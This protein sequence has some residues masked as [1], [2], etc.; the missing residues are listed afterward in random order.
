MVKS[1]K[2]TKKSK[3]AYRCG[4]ENKPYYGTYMALALH[5]NNKHG[6]DS[7]AGTIAP[8]SVPMKGRKRGR[9]V[10]TTKL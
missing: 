1:E 10:D 2:S 9:P 3:T 5:V 8:G 4:C 6:G 7:P